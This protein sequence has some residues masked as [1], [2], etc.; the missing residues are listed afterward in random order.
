MSEDRVALL[1]RL[2]EA[3][4]RGDWSVILP[5]FTSDVVADNTRTRGD[6]QLVFRGPDQ[7][8]QAWE[9]S[10]DVWEAVQVDMG[11]ATAIGDQVVVRL[12]GRFRGRQGI[13]LTAR[14]AWL[15]TFRGDKISE[16]CFYQEEHEALEA[17]RTS[18]AS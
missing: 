7:V 2:I 9:S 13:E 16:I 14:P 1:E 4:N 10:N 15:F 5:H 3:L 18:R 6:N 11:N 8:R 17:A 12:S